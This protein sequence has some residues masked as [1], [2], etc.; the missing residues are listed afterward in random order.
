[1]GFERLA[2][3]VLLVS[4]L[5]ILCLVFSPTAVGQTPKRGGTVVVGYQRDV[6]NIDPHQWTA[7]VTRKVMLNV[8]EGLIWKNT[9]FQ[10]EPRL[11]ESWEISPDNLTVTFH[12]RR[13]VKF[14]NGREMVAD[15]VKYSIERVMDPKTGSQVLPDMECVKEVKVLDKYTVKV[16]FKRPSAR[17]VELFDGD[18]CAIVPREEVEKHGDL[19]QFACGTGP[20]RLKER[21]SMQKVVLE[22]NEDYYEKGLP[23][24]DQVI[25]KII[26]EEFSII[27]DLKAGNTDLT[28]VCP[29]EM[30]GDLKK[31]PGIIYEETPSSSVSF[32]AMNTRVAP[33]NDVRVR[34]AVAYAVDVKQAVD[35]AFQ[36]LAEP[37]TSL[38]PKVGPI[39]IQASWPY[40]RD[41]KKAKALL[42]AAGYPNGVEFT[43][44]AL[45]T[46]QTTRIMAEVLQG[47]LAEAGIKMNIVYT[48]PG[49]YEEKVVRKHDFQ[50]ATDGTSEYPDPDVKLYIRLHSGSQTN[51]SGYSNRKVDELLELG[52]STLDPEKRR[53][54][55]QECIDLVNSE[56]PIL[57]LAATKFYVFYRD[58][59]KG[60]V[61]DPVTMLYFKTVWVEK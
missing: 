58:R 55:Y 4:V 33:F 23:Y 27:A 26:P 31:T 51:I 42:A 18:W 60:F 12:L 29:T 32:M 50:A 2:R 56:V 30:Q 8:Y 49:I 53:A 6:L 16:I 25:F 3:P 61:I 54:I 40:K 5:V 15:D 17:A 21:V 37:A 38:V 44:N 47:Q 35:A 59:L 10:V 1:M 24:L 34:Q 41:V 22:R 11:A 43:L 39:K 19:N 57:P 48:E 52:R 14:H 28:F 20:F 46:A 9:K 7:N 36:G 45:G 13:G